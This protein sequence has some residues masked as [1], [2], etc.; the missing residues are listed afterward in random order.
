[1]TSNDEAPIPPVRVRQWPTFGLGQLYR[2][3]HVT[4]EARLTGE[5]QSLRTYYVLASL[6]EYGELSQQQVCDRIDMDRSDMVRLIDTLDS[7][8]HVQ[9]HRDPTTAAATASPSPNVA[10]VP[11]PAA[12]RFSPMR[13]TRSSPLS[14]SMS[15]KP[16]IV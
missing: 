16:C 14:P 4:I 2:S 13:P 9:R 7:T 5:R 11:L 15:A 3:A 10:A 6:A 8:G 12:R 1:M